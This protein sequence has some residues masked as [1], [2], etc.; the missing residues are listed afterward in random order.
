MKKKNCAAHGNCLY[1]YTQKK[2][3][4]KLKGKLLYNNNKTAEHPQQGRF[5]C[6]GAA[7]IF[8]VENFVFPCAASL[9]FK[10][11]FTFYI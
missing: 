6:S 2:N 8:P 7:A 9:M 5:Q 10:W 3:W 11:V 1:P 4:L